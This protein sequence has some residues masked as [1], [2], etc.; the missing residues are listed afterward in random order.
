MQTYQASF[1]QLNSM[2][3]SLYLD[4]GDK[5]KAIDIFLKHYENIERLKQPQTTYED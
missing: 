1:N 3:N 2:I 4:N 5:L